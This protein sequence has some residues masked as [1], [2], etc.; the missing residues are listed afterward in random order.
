MKIDWDRFVMLLLPIKLRVK[1]L[2]ALIRSMLAGIVPLHNRHLNYKSDV[3]YKLRHGSQVWSLEAVLNDTFDPIDRRIYI[4]DGD[5]ENLTLL[6]PDEDLKAVILQPDGDGEAWLIHPDEDY[7]PSNYDF[8]VVFPFALPSG[9]MAHARGLVDYFKL[10][11]KR[12]K[13]Q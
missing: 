12:Y 1:S 8:I 11:G 4:K 10:A 6:Y 2:F 13:I 3:E 7:E 9:E 5:A